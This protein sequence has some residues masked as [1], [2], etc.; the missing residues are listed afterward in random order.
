MEQPELVM[1]FLTVLGAPLSLWSCGG[2]FA[3]G[4]LTK[5]RW[6]NFFPNSM[7]CSTRP[8][9][10][11]MTTP[12]WCMG[13]FFPNIPLSSAS[14]TQTRTGVQLRYL[15]EVPRRPPKYHAKW[16]K[17]WEF[18]SVC[19]SLFFQKCGN[20]V[21]LFRLNSVQMSA[22]ISAVPFVFRFSC[23]LSSAK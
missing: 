8:K 15:F 11:S 9:F 7:S 18:L 14:G 16:R 2:S 23:G 21:F 6:P 17:H 13:T 12:T 5:H 4:A 10:R 3:D 19:V 20:S 22:C 1:K